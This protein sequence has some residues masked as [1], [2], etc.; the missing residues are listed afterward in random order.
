MKNIKK[1]NEHSLTEDEYLN[2]VYPVLSDTDVSTIIDL[3]LDISEEYGLTDK[4]IVKPGYSLDEKNCWSSIVSFA[5]VKSVQGSSVVINVY[6]DYI[7]RN[8]QFILCII[9]NFF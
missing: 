8:N 2:K 5:N 4:G 9:F 1:Y 3:F 7:N 6:K